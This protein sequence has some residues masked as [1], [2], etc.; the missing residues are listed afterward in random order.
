M[1]GGHIVNDFDRL[2][3]NT[4][5][6]F[7]MR[8]ELLDEMEMF[9]F[10]GDEKG[11]SFMCLAPSSYDKYLEHIET[12]LKTDSPLAFGL[13]PNAEIDFRTTQSENLFR[14][15]IE[16]QP[17][18]AAAGDATM[19]PLELAKQGLEM[20]L[21][22]VGEKK[23]ECDEIARNLEE[24]G[25]YQ[26]VFI[27]ECEA[28]N[29]LLAE[30][31]RSLNE[32]L[33]GFAGELTMS[34][35]MEAVQESLFLDRVPKSWEKLA[36]PSMRPLGS[37]LTNLEA[38]LQQLE[39]WTQNPADIPRVTW[40]SG[41]INPQSFLTAIMQVTAQKNQWEL[42]KL[43]IQTDVLKRRNGEVDAPSRDGAYIHGLFHMG[44]RWDRTTQW[45]G[46][47]AKKLFMYCKL[48]F[49]YYMYVHSV[50]VTQ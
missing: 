18:D 28:M 9:P 23:F 46:H 3:A 22:R 37:W 27:Q 10:V 34:D 24:M 43:V 35:A 29:G 17:R 6:D 44:A 19:S 4:Y 11:P 31:V 36:F 45:I 15:L 25:P 14:T 39:E 20:V 33:L 5:L 7:Y 50:P 41:M 16:L 2:L 38:R 40:L 1:Y 48:Q 26:N 8:D 12:E 21:S 42:D 47:I 49:A 13:H 32:L 30:V